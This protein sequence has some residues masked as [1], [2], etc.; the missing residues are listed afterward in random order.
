VPDG[1]DALI[2]LTV[3]EMGVNQLR[4]TFLHWVTTVAFPVN[5]TR[6]GIEL[7]HRPAREWRTDSAVSIEAQDWVKEHWGDWEDQLKGWLEKRHRVLTDD[8][9]TQLEIDRVQALDD[10]SKRYQSRQNEVNSRLGQLTADAERK[11]IRR[12]FEDASQGVFDTSERARELERRLADAE[13]EVARKRQQLDEISD[14]VK[15]E[16]QR[17]IERVIPKRH[18][19]APH[20]AMVFPVAVELRVK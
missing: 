8:L 3:E 5:G 4:E 15:Q 9:T 10:A 18:A 6:V 2:L 17:I 12:E 19:L 20:G 14:Q 11:R 16:R 13:A 1:A 7:P